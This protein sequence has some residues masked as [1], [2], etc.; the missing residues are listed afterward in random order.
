MY[1]ALLFT[2]SYLRYIILILLI[3]VTI[4]SLLGMINKNPY[5]DRDNKLSLSLFICTHLQLLIGLILFFVSPVVQF[6]GTAM[7]DDT[8]R[9]WLAEHGIAM[10]LAIVFITLAR[11]SSKKMTDGTAKHRRMF[12]FNMIALVIIVVT[13]SI[14]GRDFLLFR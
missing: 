3:V 13:I 14:S 9:Y 10:L 2:H 5:T 8:T 1:Y 12:I 7:K 11:T 6:S 4:T